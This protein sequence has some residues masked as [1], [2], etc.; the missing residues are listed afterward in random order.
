[1]SEGWSFT[2]E[3]LLP[4]SCAY[5]K[6]E[7]PKLTKTKENQLWYCRPL[8]K[9]RSLS[10]SAKVSSQLTQDPFVELGYRRIQSLWLS[11]ALWKFQENIVEILETSR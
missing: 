1:M 3:E 2:A 10:T 8:F 9:T 7:L 4:S 6:C 11:V 5:Q